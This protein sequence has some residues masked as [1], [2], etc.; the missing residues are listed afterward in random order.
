MQ[1][2]GNLATKFKL[3]FIKTIKFEETPGVSQLIKQQKLVERNFK[4]V[5]SSVVNK[6]ITLER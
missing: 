6:R 1:A 2:A 4:S 5:F 3:N